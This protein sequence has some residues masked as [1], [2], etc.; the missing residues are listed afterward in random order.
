MTGLVDLPLEGYSYTW[1]HKTASKMSK[2]DTLLISEGLLTTFPSLSA[3]CLDRNL[4]D[5]RHILMRELNVDYGPTPFRL[6][7]SWFNK[8]G[9]DNMVEDS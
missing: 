9:F 4:S 6:F 1:S 2:L 8:K 7:H 5:H 3:L